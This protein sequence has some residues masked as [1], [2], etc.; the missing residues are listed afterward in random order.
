MARSKRHEFSVVGYLRPRTYKMLS[1]M[2]YRDY[3]TKSEGVGT[4]LNKFFNS[5]PVSEQ[6]ALLQLFD[7]MPEKAKKNPKH[8]S[9][10]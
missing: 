4:I 10:H 7:E 5:L 3:V 2:C 1:A 8:L 6:N 9:A